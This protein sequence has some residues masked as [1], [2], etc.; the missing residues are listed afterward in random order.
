MLIWTWNGQR[1]IRVCGQACQTAEAI[2]VPPSQTTTA[3]AGMRSSRA[4]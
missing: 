1:C 3:G 4:A 2:P